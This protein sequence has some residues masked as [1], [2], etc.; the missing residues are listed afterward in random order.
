[1]N[2]E[3]AEKWLYD[4]EK[5]YKAIGYTGTFGL[6]IGVNPLIKRYEIGERS[7]E[8]YEEIMSLE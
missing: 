4:V 2:W 8:L 7:Q 6:V 5:L 1:M 3:E